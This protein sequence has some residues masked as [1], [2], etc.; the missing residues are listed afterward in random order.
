MNCVFAKCLSAL[1]ARNGKLKASPLFFY[2]FQEI[3]D[4]SFIILLIKNE[5]RWRSCYLN[6]SVMIY[7]HEVSVIW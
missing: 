1:D 3:I 2:L 6:R 4:S 5:A 7:V